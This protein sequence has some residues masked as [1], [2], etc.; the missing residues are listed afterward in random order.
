MTKNQLVD[1]VYLA[2]VGG[3][4][5]QDSNVQR[6]DIESLADAAIEMA[7]Y[8][9]NREQSLLNLRQASIT[10]V[11]PQSKGRINST[12]YIEPVQD[13]S[14]ALY[15]LPLPA[16]PIRPQH[17]PLAEVSPK[18]GGTYIY[19][20]SQNDAE[21]AMSGLGLTFYWLESIGGEARLYIRG[22]GFPVC[23]HVVKIQMPLSEIPGD[24]N[25]GLGESIAMRAVNLLTDF[26]RNQAMSP[27][28]LRM[29]QTDDAEEA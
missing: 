21:S 4:P 22:I 12:Y 29:N 7:A 27:Q 18:Q 28:D 25:L 23:E 9:T 20:T 24:V 11:L 8:E 1:Q 5:T 10:G 3:K 14:R 19:A 13:S 17:G 26:F 15:Y 2:V 6:V 16:Q